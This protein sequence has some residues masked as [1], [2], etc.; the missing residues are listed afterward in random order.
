MKNRMKIYLTI[1]DVADL[2]SVDI[3][4]IERLVHCG[5]HPEWRWA[6]PM[7]APRSV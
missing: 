5:I 7:K 6:R 2:C 3:S 4:V 1:N